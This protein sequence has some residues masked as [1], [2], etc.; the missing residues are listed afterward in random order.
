M[1]GVTTHCAWRSP[2][3]NLSNCFHLRRAGRAAGRVRRDSWISLQERTGCMILRYFIIRGGWM[4]SRKR[5]LERETD[6]TESKKKIEEWRFKKTDLD[7]ANFIV[8]LFFSMSWRSTGFFFY[9]C[10]DLSFSTVPCQPD[11]YVCMLFGIDF[12]TSQS[13]FIFCSSSPIWPLL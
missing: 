4:E 5:S 11:V 2:A 7:E 1:A 9:C 13:L 12:W 10:H 6:V 3:T 8:Y